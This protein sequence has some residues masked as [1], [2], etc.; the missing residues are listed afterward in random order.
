MAY[1]FLFFY[2]CIRAIAEAIDTLYLKVKLMI[3]DGPKVK[4]FSVRDDVY[5]RGHTWI[6]REDGKI[7]VG[8]DDFA[9]KILG[10]IYKVKFPPKGYEVKKGNP[11]CVF[12]CDRGR[13]QMITPIPGVIEKVNERLTRDGSSVKRDPYGRGWLFV[14]KP[15]EEL[16]GL[17]KG[18][19]VKE[20]LQGEVEKLHTL[21]EGQL[22]YTMTDGGKLVH[23][24]HQKLSADQWSRLVKSVLS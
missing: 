12:S 11:A 23:D 16:K 22:G 4:G 19:Q 21:L 3:T 7:R 10:H 20:W 17:L 13:A 8:V 14:L 15:A 9:Q 5:Y 6:F 18:Y 2:Y 24:A 1:V